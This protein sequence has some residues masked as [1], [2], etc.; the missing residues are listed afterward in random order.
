M[1]GTLSAWK[2]H[3]ESVVLAVPLPCIT[4]TTGQRH[5]GP[6]DGDP[7]SP[8]GWGGTGCP[9]PSRPH[10]E[11]AGMSGTGPGPP[12]SETGRLLST[13]TRAPPARN[14]ARRRWA[15]PCV[16]LHLILATPPRG[17]ITPFSRRGTHWAEPPDS[18]EAVELGGASLSAGSAADLAPGAWER[19]PGRAPAPTGG[20]RPPRGKQPGTFR[21][22]KSSVGAARVLG[23]LEQMTAFT[24]AG[25]FHYC[26]NYQTPKPRGVRWCK[27]SSAR[28]CRQLAEV[29]V[30][31]TS[32]RVRGPSCTASHCAAEC[33]TSLGSDLSRTFH[34]F[35]TPFPPLS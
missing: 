21:G 26:V 15:R 33:V 1:W 25:T 13:L 20:M 32:A 4:G 7:R 16:L 29:T 3:S 11:A 24:F 2:A 14:R 12:P 8:V 5:S 34:P 28:P 17:A 31:G 30:P 19:R 10:R 18:L 27:T 9:P 23:R 35:P 6:A 22:M